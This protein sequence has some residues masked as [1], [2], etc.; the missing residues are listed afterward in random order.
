MLSL[1]NIFNIVHVVGTLLT[2]V[3][4]IIVIR[5]KSS[6]MEKL[7]GL[8]GIS[9]LIDM[10][11]YYLEMNAVDL[12]AAIVCTKFQLI[13]IL[14]MNTFWLILVFRLSD[15]PV[16]I[17]VLAVLLGIDIILG[18]YYVGFGF[19][20]VYTSLKFVQTGVF[21]HLETKEGIVFNE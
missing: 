9:I 14:L 7:L 5:E 8:V 10:I 15:V 11:A 6:R 3:L 21:P 1:F 4:C 18:F 2:A 12:H 13:A 16:N 20:K 19:D 17:P